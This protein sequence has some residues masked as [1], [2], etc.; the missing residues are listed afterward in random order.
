MSHA[1]ARPA[2]PESSGDGKSLLIRGLEAIGQTVIDLGHSA[3]EM[4]RFIGGMTLLIGRTSRWIY[5]TLFLRQAKFGQEH[6]F[7][8]MVRV[9]IRS[10]PIVAI[11]QVFIGIILALQMAPT[12]RS[13]GQ[14]QRIADIVG[15]AVFRELGPLL[16]GIV[17][18]GFAGASI[19]AELGTMVEGEEIKALRS[20]ALNPVR[21]LVMP[22]F[23]A[24]V[25]ML[26]VITVIA[27][28]VG[29]IGGL[30]T[31]SLVLNISA[32][33]YIAETKYSLVPKDFISGVIK[34]PIFG[35]LISMI[36]CYEGLHVTGGAE[37]V[38]RATTNTVVKCIVAL[39]TADVIATSLLYA[40]GI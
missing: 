2:P 17:L 30:I 1:P 9:G 13:Y 40:F 37:G 34:A 32:G 8:Q 6:L 22:R 7:S 16:S 33:Q 24:T 21:F 4:I 26:T 27:D 38:G 5:R 25:I 11:V 28:V 15:I 36:A 23:L 10:I 35:L 12:L 3:V 20:I 39:I 29:V 31:S 18:S 19:A 14:I